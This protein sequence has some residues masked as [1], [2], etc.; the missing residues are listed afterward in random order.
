MYRIST[1]LIF[2]SIMILSGCSTTSPITPSPLLPVTAITDAF[3]W[4][5]DQCEDPVEDAQTITRLEGLANAFLMPVVAVV[6]LARL[7]ALYFVAIP[8]AYFGG[9]SV[10]A[11]AEKINWILPYPLAGPNP[12]KVS[13]KNLEV[14][15]SCLFAQ[16][17]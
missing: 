7:T 10:T 3:V 8:I 1:L 2:V 12:D 5:E 9:P 16:G 6:Y 11:T 4:L 13:Y 17:G 15:E 14:Q